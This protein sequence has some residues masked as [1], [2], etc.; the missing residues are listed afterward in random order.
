ME[1]KYMFNKTIGPMNDDIAYNNV[2]QPNCM[3]VPV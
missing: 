3:R 1:W 2:I